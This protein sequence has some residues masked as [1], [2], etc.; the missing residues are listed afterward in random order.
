M[1]DV[2][3]RNRGMTMT[4][5]L[6]LLHMLNKTNQVGFQM[7]MENLICKHPVCYDIFDYLL[8]FNTHFVFSSFSIFGYGNMFRY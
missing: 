6:T 7:H 2:G 3:G 1:K 8:T 5:Q 4:V